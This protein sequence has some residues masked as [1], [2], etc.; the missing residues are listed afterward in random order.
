[1][2]ISLWKMWEIPNIKK[3]TSQEKEEEKEKERKRNLFLLHLRHR[4]NKHES[5]SHKHGSCLLARDLSWPFRS[6]RTVFCGGRFSVGVFG[7][8]S[9]SAGVVSWNSVC[10]ILRMVGVVGDWHSVQA[11]S[12]DDKHF[13]LSFRLP[14]LVYHVLTSI[15]YLQF[16][17][18]YPFTAAEGF[19]NKTPRYKFAADRASER[20]LGQNF[21]KMQ[22]AFS[23][24]P[25][26]HQT[27][28]AFQTLV[29]FRGIWLIP[30]L[31]TSSFA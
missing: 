27:C 26:K 24:F 7:E 30:L 12:E 18:E 21:H 11:Y 22:Q 28:T 14:V 2:E 8:S 4:S 6:R 13:N 23:I 31:V 5:F 10:Q 9:I 16:F 25:A 20:I 29:F 19:T 3:E 17:H 15:I 1:M